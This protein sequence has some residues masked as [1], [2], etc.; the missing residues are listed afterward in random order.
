MS[1]QEMFELTA[2]ISCI[3]RNAAGNDYIK[4]SK[5]VSDRN[6]KTVILQNFH[7]FNIRI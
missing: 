2:V 5:F 7:S 4:E 6:A 3:R 1:T